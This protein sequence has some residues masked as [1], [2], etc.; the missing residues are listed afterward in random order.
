[1]LNAAML[2]KSCIFNSH[3]VQEAMPAFEA[4]L[5]VVDFLIGIRLELI[6]I[7]AHLEDTKPDVKF[8]IGWMGKMSPKGRASEESSI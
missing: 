3:P 4:L 8:N 1:M 2:I 5:R 6:P 7:Q